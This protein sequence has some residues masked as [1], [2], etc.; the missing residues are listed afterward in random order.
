[1]P[2]TSKSST[3]TDARSRSGA[4]PRRESASPSLPLPVVHPGEILE[5]EFLLPL[6]LSVYRL[7]KAIEVPSQRL[8]DVVLGKRAI[9]ADTAIRLARYF[10]TSEQFWLNLQTTY[11]LERARDL[12]GASLTKIRR[13]TPKVLPEKPTAAP[14]AR[15]ATRPRVA[16]AA[17]SRRAGRAA[18]AR[19]RQGSAAASRKR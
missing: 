12:A 17:A 9:T 8:N 3:I 15:R 18:A 16:A 19:T 6:S 14:A 2:T 13:F 10:G 1:M 5:E 11:D 7:A 4:R